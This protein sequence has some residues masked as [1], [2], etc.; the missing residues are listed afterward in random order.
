M[1]AEGRAGTP[2]AAELRAA[3]LAAL[4]EACVLYLPIAFVL[5]DG[6]GSARMVALFAAPF[7]ALFVAGVV[8]ACRYRASARTSAMAV[9]VAVVIGGSLGRG[10]PEQTLLAAVV[11]LLVALRVLSL[12]LRDWRTPLEA[13][14]AVGATV[15]GVETIIAAAGEGVWRAPLLVFTPLFFLASLASRSTT[16]WAS[17]DSVDDAPTRNLWIRRATLA[18]VA[19]AGAAAGAALLAVRGGVLDR[20]GSWLSP[21]AEFLISGLAA[22]V[23][24]VARPLIWFVERMGV[25][26]DAIRRFLEDLRRQAQARGTPEGITRSGPSWWGRVFA[27]LAFAGIGYAAYRGIRRLRPPVGSPEP[28]PRAPAA[29]AGSPLP[30]GE[31]V[32]APRRIR[33]EPPADAVRRWYGEAL[34]ALRKREVVKDPWLTPAEFVPGV[35]VAFPAGADEFAGLT[36]AYQDVRYGN[37]EMEPATLR[38]LEEGQRRIIEA[39]LR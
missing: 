10:D 2:D 35:R 24:V 34:A 7:V 15:L 32:P 25:D 14:I 5:S 16:V 4:A 29:E 33:H 36:S 6:R 30:V 1:I 20:V 23:V 26:P 38:R 8:L 3:G 12:G 17:A 22:V 31:P 28:E 21:L 11:G 37:L 39:L 19:F 13:E 18:A 27:L 9:I